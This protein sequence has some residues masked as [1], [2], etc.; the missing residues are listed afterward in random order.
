MSIVHV[1]SSRNRSGGT[2]QA[3]LLAREQVRSGHRVLFCA[4]PGAGVFELGR[5]LGIEFVVLETGSL[6]AQ[7]RSSRKLRA[8][9]KA[10][11]ADVVHAHHTKGHN[12]AL[13]A[14]FGG[15]FPP[16]IA[17]RGVLFPPEFPAKFRSARTAAVITNSRRVA[18]VLTSC[19]VTPE[20]VHV[21]YNARD[22]ADSDVLRDRARQFREE[23]PGAGSAPVVGAV[24]SA[25]PEK[26]MQV[27]VEAA[28]RILERCP[29]ARFVLVG[30][31]TERFEPRLRE[32][33]LR[34]RFWLPGHRS[35]AVALM[36]LFDVFVLPS[37][38]M[39]S[40]PNVLLEAMDVGLP[41]VGSDVGGVA[42]IVEE[43]RTG[44]VVPPGDPQALANAVVAVLGRDD[45][46]RAWG[47]T[48]RQ[49][50]RERFSPDR[51]CRE[52]LRVYE[53]LLG[54]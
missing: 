4:P 26:G 30:A 31:G 51:K 37:I 46:G 22:P 33:G 35:D 10:A 23:L 32:L 40:C 17:N 2:R 53:R 43:G 42:E 14:T 5:G 44:L 21:V 38:D 11:G 19:G 27:L 28:P 47:E 25:R 45:R 52:T 6:V 34:D 13:L 12:V 9:V 24:S 16:V 29:D 54:D 39:E 8:V 41:V 20:K 48:G 15:R 50:V 1:T 49:T 3:L 7:W 18:G 36:T